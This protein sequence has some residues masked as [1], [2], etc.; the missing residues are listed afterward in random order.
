MAGGALP[1]SVD[2]FLPVVM[3]LVCCQVTL[4]LMAVRKGVRLSREEMD[5]MVWCSSHSHSSLG[6]TWQSI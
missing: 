5:Y 2:L 4:V 1:F 6:F 3:L